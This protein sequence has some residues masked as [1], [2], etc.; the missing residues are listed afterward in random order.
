MN[1]PG[2]VIGFVNVAHFIDHY[3]MLIFAA[4]VIVMAPAL[5]MS[6]S[7]L[8]PY[9]TPGFIAFAYLT[10]H[11]CRRSRSSYDPPAVRPTLPGR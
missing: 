6:Y 8:L 10:Q 11:T 7:E 9:A 3:S 1:S 4:A 2:R 5:G